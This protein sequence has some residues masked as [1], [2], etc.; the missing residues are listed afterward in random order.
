MSN[1]DFDTLFSDLE[2]DFDAS[3]RLCCIMDLVEVPKRFAGDLLEFF[4]I[5]WRL[6]FVHLTHL[7]DATG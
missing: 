6:T 4:G 2:D 1:I 5:H 7:A 3:G